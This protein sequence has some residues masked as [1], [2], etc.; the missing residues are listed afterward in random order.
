M[1]NSYRIRTNINKDKLVNV[2]LQNDVDFLEIL[3][4]KI[5]QK[6]FYRLHT[7]NYGVV[8]G[9]VL[10]NGGFGVPNVKVSIFVPLDHLS[11]ND[12]IITQYY[13][14]ESIYQKDNKGRRYNLL[15][16][17]QL[18]DCY[19]VVGTFPNKRAVLDNDIQI[20]IFDK[21]WKYTTVTNKSGD[22]MLC[23]IPIG[24]QTLHVDLDLSDCG[25]LS[26]KPHDM[27]PKGYTVSSFDSAN[28]FKSGTNLDNLTQIVSQD[29]SINVYALWGDN[30]LDDTIGIT[31]CDVDL[32]YKFEP[33]CIFMGS[34][35]TDGD[36]NAISEDCTPTKTCGVNRKLTTCQGTIE[37][38]RKTPDGLVEEYQI[39]GNQLI[40]G[41]GTW[42]YQ[43]PMNLDYITTDE[44]GNIVP[45]DDIEKGVA[46]RTSVRFRISTVETGEAS[47]KHRAKFLV[48][49]NPT[50]DL[51]NGQF[52]TID[53]INGG[54]YDN[55][56]FN[57]GSN[58][59]KSDFRD[60]YWNKVYSIKSYI[61]RLQKNNSHRTEN[62][63]GIRTVNYSET[64]NTF[65]FNNFRFKFPTA[66]WFLCILSKIIFVI[67][68]MINAVLSP[69]TY[70]CIPPGFKILGFQWC[71]FGFI[72]CI[73][74]SIEDDT[75][76]DGESIIYAPGCYA[77]NRPKGAKIGDMGGYSDR[78]ERGLADDSEV[79]KLDFFN[80]WINGVLYYPLWFWKKTKKKKY[81]FGLFS[82]KATNKFCSADRNIKNL[83]LMQT[84][85]NSFSDDQWNNEK[86]IQNHHAEIRLKNGVIKEVE[87]KDG[88]RIYYYTPCVKPLESNQDQTRVVRLFATDIIL[89][90]SISDCD[91]DGI[92]KLY[93]RLP[94]SSVNVPF[95][96][97]LKSSDTN[98]VNFTG[99]DW[100]HTEG[101]APQQYAQGLFFDLS[102]T[103]AT[104]Y[105]KSIIN[106]RRLCEL[107]VSFDGAW[108]NLRLGN[109][110]IS[111]IENTPDGLITRYEMEDSESRAMFATMNST[112][113]QQFKINP[114]TRYQSYRFNYLY[115]N[116]FDGGL[117]K[118]AQAY[119][120]NRTTDIKNQA[121]I[122]FRCQSVRASGSTVPLSQPSCYDGINCKMPVYENSFYFYFGLHQGSTALERFL[123]EYDAACVTTTQL[124]FSI[125]VD[126]TVGSWCEPYPTVKFTINNVVLPY[127]LRVVGGLGEDVFKEAELMSEEITLI[128][129]N[130]N[131]TTTELVETT[132]SNESSA[133]AN[134]VVENFTNGT[135]TVYVTD[136]NGRTVH[137]V[138]DILQEPLQLN[139]EI[140]NLS[141]EYTVG[142]FVKDKDS[143]GRINIIYLM[144]DGI[145]YGIKSHSFM[146]TDK[147]LVKLECYE[148]TNSTTLLG[149]EKLQGGGTQ[150][151]FV[152]MTYQNIE[153]DT[154]VKSFV[155]T[156]GNANGDFIEWY[157]YS[158]TSGEYVRC[159][160]ENHTD[161]THGDTELK[162][163]SFRIRT[164]DEFSLTATLYCGN[165]ASNDIY[166]ENI[167][168]LNGSPLG[169]KLN[170]VDVKYLKY[171]DSD[172]WEKSYDP[173]KY[174]FPT[175][176]YELSN[177]TETANP[178]SQDIVC[179]KMKS[180][181]NT[182]KG[183]LTSENSTQCSFEA[184]GGSKPIIYS[185]APDYSALSVT[186]NA[187][188]K[189]NQYLVSQ[190]DN[191][192]TFI[193]KATTKVNGN[194]YTTKS[195]PSS[196]DFNQNYTLNEIYEIND[197]GN[198][199]GVIDDNNNKLTYPSDI[200]PIEKIT[201]QTEYLN[202]KA[203][204]G[205]DG[206]VKVQSVDRRFD[207]DLKIFVPY[208]TTDDFIKKCYL[209]KDSKLINGIPLATQQVVDNETKEISYE[210]ISTDSQT[211]YN[212]SGDT[213]SYNTNST[214]FYASSYI[215]SFGSQN[216]KTYCFDHAEF[217]NDSEKLNGY[218][219]ND[220]NQVVIGSE[221]FA[222]SSNTEN[223]NTTY[224]I[225]ANTKTYT[226][227]E[228][229]DS[230]IKYD[231]SK[232]W[233]PI[234]DVD[235][236]I[237]FSG[238]TLMTFGTTSYCYDSEPSIVKNGNI[239]HVSCAANTN[240]E[241]VSFDM[242]LSDSLSS[243]SDSLITSATKKMCDVEYD[244]DKL[245]D[246]FKYEDKNPKDITISF[247]SRYKVDNVTY[248][249]VYSKAPIVISE[250]QY[251]ELI[252]ENEDLKNEQLTRLLNNKKN[253][254]SV[255][256]LD[257]SYDESYKL[258]SSG[259]MIDKS[260]NARIAD[261]ESFC[262]NVLF[263]TPY[264]VTSSIMEKGT[265]PIYLLTQRE[266]IDSN[267]NDSR[268][269]R[270]ATVYSIGRKIDPIV[271][272]KV[273]MLVPWHKKKQTSWATDALGWE[274]LNY[275]MNRWSGCLLK[276]FYK[277]PNEEDATWTQGDLTEKDVVIGFSDIDM[278]VP[279]YQVYEH[280]EEKV[281]DMRFVGGASVEVDDDEEDD[282]EE[283]ET[284]VPNW[285]KLQG[286][287][288]GKYL[289]IYVRVNG[290]VY[291]LK[292][293]LTGYKTW[294]KNHD[295]GEQWK[296]N[297][298]TD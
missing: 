182:C 207:Y 194:Y 34:L 181:M 239:S 195:T 38:I 87:N 151:V 21:Y 255:L 188:N 140:T 290:V 1:E 196:V 113:L 269:K 111:Y 109:N 166:N 95:L 149:Y 243:V 60:L 107:G 223:G 189:V 277:Q 103:N 171:E 242:S 48:P 218:F 147:S 114:Y 238:L 59:R 184:F 17:E 224:Q 270:N 57:F 135:Y 214:P 191:F 28:Q 127:T 156:L 164:A 43:I 37:M 141:T 202:M 152:Q 247:K 46:T 53:V 167:S 280:N 212:Y 172:M 138:I 112:G 291:R 139:M 287:D 94:I 230:Q 67:V 18:N 55:K 153:E 124:P 161:N 256:Y 198:Y 106:A 132:D 231:N 19:R 104:T 70:I 285:K 258:N 294:R 272:F 293:R 42:C 271:E 220:K 261:D 205:K 2:K 268:L 26:Q 273:I 197:L 122:D 286:G 51:K 50:L 288:I 226:S 173:S 23:G 274:Y 41:N 137:E 128:G 116:D 209:L 233:F 97:S 120:K 30:S 40:D 199:I 66:Y 217:V 178:T 73:S 259:W 145:P 90:G 10:A 143:C 54:A 264:K 81:F 13:P 260:S 203:I 80:D 39:Q 162:A 228:I 83:F 63:T 45:T 190:S 246:C 249:N 254:C 75:S 179:W 163:F 136:A 265:K 253:Y 123:N 130:K 192:W 250:D 69:L 25:I 29:N 292:A 76:E 101:K 58:T 35:I 251:N 96:V 86:N 32:P 234:F 180:I 121:Y 295:Y 91:M 12:D 74:F 93:R 183:V 245:T 248:H 211:Q 148:L 169:L 266:Y 77:N 210:L 8:V 235:S 201:L 215:K 125:D 71:L 204:N 263:E 158:Q 208:E 240:G 98:K 47:S 99:M 298:S 11:D 33:T 144:I 78:V 296:P 200:K 3:S 129:K 278:V 84:C 36:T 157:E 232:P 20:E 150:T 61:P 221:I 68:A 177:V 275:K 88:L 6:E 9:R 117:N 119:T 289:Y 108:D 146:S 236:N 257:E 241:T 154:N 62:Y 31:R 282:E 219:I 206:Y 89:L 92:P 279:T 185:A 244:Y 142:N 283:D 186:N 27:Y 118:P 267:F 65:P 5:S 72:H 7:S 229:L 174:R 237:P 222:V 160:D 175:N 16:D 64:N 262:Q 24:N 4:L 115:P 82:K 165:E 225:T 100:T 170:N 276:I 105:R 284:L 176:R 22:Y 44:F 102:C 216:L 297:K 213:I 14:F 281:W 227:N 52:P 131:D 15:P 193:G 155:D 79:I 110:S 168:I 49:N 159:S 134:Y 133:N 126:A 85:A 187:N 252:D 56:N